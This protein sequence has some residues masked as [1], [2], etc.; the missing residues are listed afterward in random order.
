MRDEMNDR[1][2]VDGGLGTITGPPGQDGKSERFGI[3]YGVSGRVLNG[4]GP[5]SQVKCT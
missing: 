1:G 2:R 5:Y 4:E 3:R